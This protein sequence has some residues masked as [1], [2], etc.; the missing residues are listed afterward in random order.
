MKNL[1]IV[2]PNQIFPIESIR[3]F[4]KSYKID[5][6][7]LLEHPIY[8]GLDPE[9][10]IN[11]NKL[12]LVLHRATFYFYKDYL[13]NNG[14]KV[15]H[16]KVHEYQLHLLEELLENYKNVYYIDVP[17]RLLDTRMSSIKT[18]KKSNIKRVDDVV[19]NYCLKRS[20]IDAFLNTR[21]GKKRTTHDDFYRWCRQ[22]LDILMDSNDKPIGGS[23]S[24]DKY[25]R[26]SPPPD[27]KS[28]IPKLPTI[29]ADDRVYIDMA[30]GEIAKEFPE[31][32]GN[33]DLYV[34]V[35]FKTANKWL[36]DFINNRLLQFGAYQDAVLVGEPFMYHSILS[37]MLNCGLL[38]PKDLIKLAVSKYYKTTPQTQELLYSVEGFVRQILG[39][40]EWQ[41]VQY[42]H[43]YKILKGGNYYNNYNKLTRGWYEGK[44]GIQPIDD[45][46]KMGYKYGYLHHILRLMYMSNF[47]NLCRIHPHEMYKWF[48]SFPMDSY[49][50]VMVQ[51]VYSMGAGSKL[52]MTKPYITTGNY[53]VK[54]SNY[55]PDRRWMELWNA[56][57]YCFL[58]D[59]M[60]KLMAFPRVGGIMRK[61]LERKSRGEMA[62]YRRIASRFINHSP[63]TM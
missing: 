13:K 59:N 18:K 37:P 6:V 15:A 55:K 14:I 48:M 10:L 21:E 7:L 31:N 11:M 35:T 63:Q 33:T 52:N 53:I 19:I 56:L 9:R 1:W 54:M 58:E 51:N 8:F 49:D 44:L 36:L 23:Y 12:K 25:N 32:L 17:D 29:T 28:K 3:G 4:L 43:N 20:D 16:I 30:K 34:P 38:D 47:M 26:Q 22:K 5:E 50:W 24:Y 57:Y 40:R 45:T 62:Q 46:I 60:D 2:F 39:W 27:L 42:L 61:N 41:R